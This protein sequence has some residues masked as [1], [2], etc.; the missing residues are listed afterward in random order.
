MTFDLIEKYVEATDR[1][2]KPVNV[3]FRNRSTVTGLFIR[4]RDYDD[5]KKKN[6]WRIVPQSRLQLW[7][8]SNDPAL[9]RLFHGAEF[10]RLTDAG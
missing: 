5:M 8:S 4:A 2:N 7:Q 1:Y 9:S 6:F 10:S 3:H